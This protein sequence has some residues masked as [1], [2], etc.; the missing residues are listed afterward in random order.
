[1]ATFGHGALILSEAGNALIAYEMGEFVCEK[2][3]EQLYFFARGEPQYFSEKSAIYPTDRYVR[4]F[5]R[6]G[7]PKCPTQNRISCIMLARASS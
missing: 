1:M 7:L 6:V 5:R 2:E 3:P 4:E